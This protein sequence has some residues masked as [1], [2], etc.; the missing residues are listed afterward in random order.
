MHRKRT[1]KNLYLTQ[2]D[3]EIFKLLQRYRY[4][5]S[6][7]IHEFVGGRQITRFKE[8]LGDLFH[9]GYLW[10]PKQQWQH[11]NAR[12]SP[13]I[14]E[15]DKLAEAIKHEEER[16]YIRAQLVTYCDPLDWNDR[17]E[18]MKQYLKKILPHLSGKPPYSAAELAASYERV[19]ELQMHFLHRIRFGSV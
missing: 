5:R 16:K 1:G 19:I 4:L 8:R 12:Y 15:L 18:L 6:T 13:A 9:E 14:Y 11:I 17:T 7:F 10:R 2:R 3:I